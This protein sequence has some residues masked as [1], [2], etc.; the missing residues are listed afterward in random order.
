MLNV[1]FV[2]VLLVHGLIHL[3]GYTKSVDPMAI[4]QLTQNIP[5]LAGYIWLFAAV[6]FGFTAI[7]FIFKREWW[8]VPALVG[9]LISQI[10]IILVWQDAKFGTLANI[11]ILIVAIS[12]LTTWKFSLQ[13]K[14]ES[15]EVL[16]QN[17]ADRGVMVSE[18]MLKDLPLPVQSWLR[19]SGIIGK[20]VVNTV[21]LKQVGQMRLGPK[22]EWMKSEA[23]QY[24][25][26]QRP[27]FIWAA[28]MRMKGLLKVVVRDLFMNGRGE[29]QVKTALPV[30][31]LDVVNNSKLD[32]GTLQ[33]Y[34]GETVWFPSAVI[35]PLIE[36]EEI[37]AHSARAKMEYN[38][39]KGEG[40]FYFAENGD[41]SKFVAKRYKDVDAKAKKL[42]WIVEAKEIREVNGVRIPTK[43]EASWALEEGLFT[44]Y[45]FEVVEVGYNQ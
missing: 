18:E 11:L 29:M 20:E 31:I 25:S 7:T 43:I 5:Q 4:S 42:D 6:L 36:W 12:S 39:L 34:L 38:D 27:A 37:D 45:K 3:M 21:Y 17:V 33:R 44:W 13:M 40:V 15:V 35:S 23:L 1:L 26:T 14:K 22:R 2:F 24:F 30:P 8:S 16:G 28:Q 9:V 10:L 41:F 19:S 32:E